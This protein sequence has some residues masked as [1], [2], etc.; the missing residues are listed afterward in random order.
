MVRC[1]T[2]RS[3]TIL[4]FT[5]VSNLI[6]VHTAYNRTHLMTYFC[7]EHALGACAVYDGIAVHIWERDVMMT[8]G[9]RSD[10][11][12]LLLLNA[13]DFCLLLLFKYNTISSLNPI[14]LWINRS[15]VH[16]TTFVIRFAFLWQVDVLP[17]T[18][19]L[20]VLRIRYNNCDFC[21]CQCHCCWCWLLCRLCSRARLQ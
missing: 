19:P 5:W 9:S 17:R 18:T 3:Y 1:R 2:V 10:I 14:P 7:G 13:F 15:L 21:C 16:A 20:S 6:K 12:K 4:M 11:K 8:F